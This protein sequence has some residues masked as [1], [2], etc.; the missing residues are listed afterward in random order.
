MKNSSS[1]ILA[2][3]G[4]G[5]K[6]GSNTEW[7][8]S[9]LISLL[10]EKRIKTELVRLCD[11]EIKNCR[12]CDYCRTTGKLCKINDDMKKLYPKLE[13]AIGYIIGSPNYFKNVSGQMKTF[14][15]RTNTF[16]TLDKNTGKTIKKLSGKFVVGICVGGE[17]I[18]DI[19][20][21][22]ESLKRFFKA[23]DLNLI[24]SIIAKA[25]L[26]NE[27]TKDDKIDIE[28][29]SACSYII[30]YISEYEKN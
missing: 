19:K 28:L 9:Y 3:C 14:M 2:I 27:I 12:G 20:Y 30:K 10:K 1:K 6:N 11:Y 17:G 13:K 26:P 29:R 15:D 4:S 21:C 8:I 7:M 25:D 16:I 24:T 22:E 18:K 5:R 23:H